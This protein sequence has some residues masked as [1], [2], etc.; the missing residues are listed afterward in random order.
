MIDRRFHVICTGRGEHGRIDWPDLILSEDGSIQQERT[1]QAPSPVRGVV[2]GAA[3]GENV[4]GPLHRKAVVPA[5]EHRSTH[6][7][8]QWKCPQCH[9]DKP[10]S[11]DHLRA[12]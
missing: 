7:T 12:W 11:E 4:S 8:W 9:L 2:E 6:G 3:D 5:G 1:R 10:L